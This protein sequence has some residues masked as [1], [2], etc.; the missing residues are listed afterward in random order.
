MDLR[1]K[2]DFASLVEDTMKINKHQQPTGQ[3]DDSPDHICRVYTRMLLQGKLQQA[4]RWITGRDKGGLLQPTKIDSKTGDTE[5]ETLPTFI[6]LDVT[7]ST[8]EKVTSRMQNSAGLD[9]MD[10][11]AWQDYL[12]R[13]GTARTALRETVAWLAC[14]LANTRPAWVAY[15]VIMVGRLIVLDKCLG[16]HPVGVG[17]ILLH[18][19][20]R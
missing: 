18:I 2:G 4:V 9:R 7:A 16:D 15:Q 17:E 3:N 12:L 6:D 19:L 11:V 10:A 13:F 14:W 8:V 5:Y 20:G 1:E